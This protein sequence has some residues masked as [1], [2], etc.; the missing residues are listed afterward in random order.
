[1]L[2]TGNMSV[3]TGWY[4]FGCSAPRV[5]GGELGIGALLGAG[6][7]IFP[8]LIYAMMSATF[9]RSGGYYVSVSRE[10][11]PAIGFMVNFYLAFYWMTAIGFV[12]PVVV[13]PNLSALF[14]NILR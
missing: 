5:P 3:I 6:L 8:G 10:L 4:L 12:T 1:M 9:P 14:G 11:H 13:I 2:A 7:I